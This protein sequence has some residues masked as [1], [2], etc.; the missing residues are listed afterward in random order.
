MAASSPRLIQPDQ[1]LVAFF[2]LQDQVQLVA[3]AVAG[4]IAHERAGFIHQLQG[5]FL[6]FEI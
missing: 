2:F 4:E 5:A 1:H 6:D 3:Q